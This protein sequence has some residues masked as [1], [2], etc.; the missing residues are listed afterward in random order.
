MSGAASVNVIEMA[1]SK[2][3]EDSGERILPVSCIKPWPDQPRKFFSKTSI[4]NLAASINEVGQ[5]VPIH[6]QVD[7]NDSESFLIVDG[8]R[9]WRASKSLNRKTMRAIVLPPS[10]DDDRFIQSVV[11]N[12]GSEKHTPFETALALARIYAA[13]NHTINQIAAMF[14][15]SDVWVYQH[16]SLTKLDAKVV[17]M[18]DFDI[19]FKRRLKSAIALLLVTLPKDLQF[20]IAAEITAKQM[21]TIDA[22]HHVLKKAVEHGHTVGTAARP[23]RRRASFGTLLANTNA[24]LSALID[25]PEM[26]MGK[27]IAT[28]PREDLMKIMALSAQCSSKLEALRKAAQA[29]LQAPRKK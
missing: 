17:A 5:K 18:M 6:V 16:L 19:P 24:G 11:S 14:T 1:T 2:R 27:F 10:S 23:E 13:G 3:R 20:E 9:R 4:R 28:L 26:P 21:S 7:P 12:F 25:M 22:R 8:E 15:K 29:A